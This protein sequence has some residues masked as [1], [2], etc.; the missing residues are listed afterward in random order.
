L[1]ITGIGIFTDFVG[2]YDNIVTT[3][4]QQVAKLAAWL[5]E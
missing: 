1:R 2:K 3:D 4:Y 5:S